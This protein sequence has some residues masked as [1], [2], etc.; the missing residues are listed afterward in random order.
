[1]FAIQEETAKDYTVERCKELIL[2]GMGKPD[3]PVKIVDI[4]HR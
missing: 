2:D 3:L 4:A 1:M